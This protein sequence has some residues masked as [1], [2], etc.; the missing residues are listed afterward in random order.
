MIL[1]F[2]NTR[3][4]EKANINYEKECRSM[5]EAFYAKAEKYFHAGKRKSNVNTDS[6]D[7]AA[8]EWN[9]DCEK[10]SKEVLINTVKI[11]SYILIM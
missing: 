6:I 10:L 7:L 9:E 3:C 5:I 2:R 1:V 8:I 4:E 11:I